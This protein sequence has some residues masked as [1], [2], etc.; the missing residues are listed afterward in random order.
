MN[1]LLIILPLVAIICFLLFR[2]QNLRAGN[3]K[4]AQ[5]RLARIRLVARF[6]K[7]VCFVTFAFVICMAGVAIFWPGL[8]ADMSDHNRTAMINSPLVLSE[9]KPELEWMYPVAWLLVTAFYC[10]GIVIFYQLFRNLEW[11]ILFNKTNVHYIRLI[12]WWLLAYAFFD[13]FVELLKFVCVKPAYV[14]LVFDFGQLGSDFLCG[15]FVIFIAWIMDE[16]RK[17]SEE[18]EL[19][20]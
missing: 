3:V 16:G 10:R 2:R 18:Q 4:N 14:S 12:G 20:V 5:A 7:W 17:I 11:G 6:F 1:V 8:V 19:T 15:F 13:I 9:F